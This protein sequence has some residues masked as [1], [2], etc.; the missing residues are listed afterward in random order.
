MCL[1]VFTLS[2]KIILKVKMRLMSCSGDWWPHPMFLH[3]PPL[4]SPP[5]FHLSICP[6]MLGNTPSASR[7]RKWTKGI[8]HYV[9]AL[10]LLLPPHFKPLKS[11]RAVRVSSDERWEMWPQGPPVRSTDQLGFVTSNSVFITCMMT[12]PGV[13]YLGLWNFDLVN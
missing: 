6:W 11:N 7:H 3:S 1:W 10:A 8:S 2:Q 12:W 9:T 5:L 13:D 4:S